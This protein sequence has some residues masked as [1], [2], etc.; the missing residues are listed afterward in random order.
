[1]ISYEEIVNV[2]GEVIASSKENRAIAEW[3]NGDTMLIDFSS[4]GEPF[5]GSTLCVWSFQNT[6]DEIGYGS[7][8]SYYATFKII[9]KL[10][11][12]AERIY[13]DCF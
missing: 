7:T 6:D 8:Y 11:A 2:L 5:E 13:V 4:C 1:M 3:A 9:S 12:D 10:C